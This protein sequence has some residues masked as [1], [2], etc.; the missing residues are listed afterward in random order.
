MLSAIIAGLTTLVS[1]FSRYQERKQAE[2]AVIIAREEA[3]KELAIETIKAQMQLGQIQVG[4]TSRWFKYLTFV[5]WFGPFIISTFAPQYGAMIFD[6]WATMPQWYSQS[7][8]VIIFAVWG[9]QAGKESL[10][11]IFRGLG[12]FYTNRQKFSL[13][14]KLFYDTLRSTKGNITQA[15]V[16]LYEKAIGRMTD[17]KTGG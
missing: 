7:I 14:K 1:G 17:E 11:N 10:V 16:D 4:A 13:H 15:E 2:H 12:N 8:L 5:L 6:N 9:I 3:K